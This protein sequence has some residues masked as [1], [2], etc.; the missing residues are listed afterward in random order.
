VIARITHVLLY[1]LLTTMPVAGFIRVRAR[2]YPIELLERLGIGPWV[3]KS[4]PLADA[5][6]AVHWARRCC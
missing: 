6:Q 5:A 1:I 2:G 4:E 3:A